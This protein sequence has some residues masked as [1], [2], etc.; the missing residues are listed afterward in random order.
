MATPE[1][2]NGAAAG[3]APLLR[4]EELK[5]HFP[6]RKGVIR[7]RQVGTV[8]AVDGVSFELGR[9]EILSLV[10]ESG[11]GKSTTA[12]AVLRLQ[13]ATAGRI[14][15]DGQDITRLGPDRMQ[16]V[17][18]RI[19]MVFQ[20]PFASLNPRMKVGHI[21]GEPLVIHGLATDRRRY[22]GRVVELLEL[23][24][25][26][27]DMAERYPHEFSGGQRQRIAIARA[28]AVEPD[29][30]ICDEA[31]SALDVSIQAQILNLFME[32]Q[33][34]LGLAYLF[35][36]H[37]LSIVRHI[38]DRVAVMYLGRIVEIADREELFR[39]PRHPYTRALMAAVPVPDPEL[40]ALRPDA[41]VAGETPSARNPPPGCR[42]HPR[43]P[44]A[45]AI[46]AAEAPDLARRDGTGLV[47]C[48]HAPAGAPAVPAGSRRQS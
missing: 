19:Q 45:T 2:G 39:A 17:R 44:L 22:R 9:G 40:E 7:A 32:L 43:C 4:V 13:D 16:P 6:I 8:Q 26:S 29:L 25:L 12:L 21:I 37:N 42:F 46:C 38:S 10:G 47:A 14:V 48:H 1:A 35:I 18:R 41:P 5:V 36:S 23:V 30:V 28:L 24:G 20:D 27:P 31:V 3:R 15:F 33:Q 11:C 34:R